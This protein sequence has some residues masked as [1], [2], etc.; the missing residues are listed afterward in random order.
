MTT[1]IIGTGGIGS[2]IARKLGSGVSSAALERRRRV[3]TQGRNAVGL[4]SGSGPTRLDQLVSAVCRCRNA[5]VSSPGPR[6]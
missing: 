5:S 3:G 4:N 1:A 6:Q 2:V